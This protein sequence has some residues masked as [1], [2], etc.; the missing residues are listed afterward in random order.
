[1]NLKIA[2]RF[3]FNSDN[4]THKV[5]YIVHYQDLLSNWYIQEVNLNIVTTDFRDKGTYQSSFTVSVEKELM[6]NFEEEI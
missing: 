1:M 2:K 6:E 4:K 5:K 3:L